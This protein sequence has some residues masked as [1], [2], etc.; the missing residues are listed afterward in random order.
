M[1]KNKFKQI[2]ADGI[3]LAVPLAV[4]MY[5]FA[6]VVIVFKKWITPI[7]IQLGIDSILGGLTL[8]IFT[9]IGIL[10]MILLLGLLMQF[11]FVSLIR[12]KLESI[13][14]RFIPALNVLKAILA[15]KLKM[16]NAKSAWKPVILDHSNKYNFAFK[17]EESE[18]MG[19][20]FILNGTSIHEGEIAILE[21]ENY[22]YALV[23]AHDMKK[24][25]SNFGIGSIGLIQKAF[26]A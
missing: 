14:L 24:T 21:K 4:V 5:V 10:I 26:N 19:V 20:F 17:V 3:A 15:D 13:L 9:F 11:G 7:A 16:E 1:K 12:V 6:K 23:D 8:T 22:S 2:L 25:L 18:D